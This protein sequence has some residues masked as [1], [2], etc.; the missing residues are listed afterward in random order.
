MRLRPIR[1]RYRPDNALGIPDE[2]EHVGLTAQ[3]VRAVIPE[4]VH[5]RDDGYL[6]LDQ[7]AIIWAMLNAIRQQE[8]RIR[9]LEAK[10]G[11]GH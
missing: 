3:D 7:D 6:M 9:E 8:H 2:G 5:E 1:Y 10:L 4:A 11:E